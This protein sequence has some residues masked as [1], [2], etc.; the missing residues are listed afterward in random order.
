MRRRY[1]ILP[2]AFAA[3]LLGGCLGSFGSPGEGTGTST[4]TGD[5]TGGVTLALDNPP[6]GVSAV[7]TPANV[8]IT[9]ANPVTVKV[10]LTVAPGATPT[11]TASVAVKAASGTIT[12][13]ATLGVSIP[14][15]LL[16]QI[17]PNV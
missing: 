16:I 17:A 6:A 10:D 11:T 1:S 4:G 13:S 14:A 12:S 15:E 3:S 9:D 7:F 5:G 2:I 8:N